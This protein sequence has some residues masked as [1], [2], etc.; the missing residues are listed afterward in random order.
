MAA[1]HHDLVTEFPELREKIHSFKLSN[2]HFAKL[3]DEYHLLNREVIRLEAE[4]IPVADETFE[5]FKKKRLKLKD[6][7]YAILI[8]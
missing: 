3:F 6:E 1:V 8:S 2:A 4:D 7:L 5:D